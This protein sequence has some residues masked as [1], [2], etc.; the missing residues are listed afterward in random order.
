MHRLTQA[1]KV[2]F[3]SVT[4]RAGLIA[5]L[6]GVASLMSLGFAIGYSIASRPDS[7]FELPH[8]KIESILFGN[9]E[10]TATDGLVITPR[11]ISV[12]GSSDPRNCPQKYAVWLCI[13]DSSGYVYPQGTALP[14]E[15]PWEI[16]RVI[17]GREDPLDRGDYFQMVIVIVDQTRTAD[18]R[19]LSALESPLHSLDEGMVIS[20][21]QLIQRL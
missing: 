4:R 15:G 5:A 12:K 17:V 3:R 10:A 13:I 21:I 9:K 19:V 11:V 14:V 16:D 2:F 7:S 8:A 18:M 20:D 6:A 1:T